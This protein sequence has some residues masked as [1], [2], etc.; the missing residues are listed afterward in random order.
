MANLVY[1]SNASEN[2]HRF[3]QRLGLP[4]DRIPVHAGAEPLTATEPYV[5]IVPTYGAREERKVP[6]QVARFLN[7][8]S[9]R[10]LLRG[11]IASGN[12]NFGTEFCAAGHQI[13]EKC[14]VPL[15]YRFEIAGTP[16]DHDRVRD[17]LTTFW[18]QETP[19][20]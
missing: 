12:A 17:G 1:F 10:D 7:Q 16:H 13:A 14:R 15:L 11:V 19:T 18:N 3:I 9:N 6:S 4:A 5:L 20:P 8:R 2:T